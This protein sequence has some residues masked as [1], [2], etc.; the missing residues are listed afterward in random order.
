[1]FTEPVRFERLSFLMAVVIYGFCAP[2]KSSFL[3]SSLADEPAGLFRWPADNNNVLVL[4]FILSEVELHVSPPVLSFI[5]N[6]AIE[7]NRAIS[8]VMK[9]S[10]HAILY[11]NR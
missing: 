7:A 4:S 6:E 8:R 11:R 9:Q 2:L 1:M 5:L 3:Y 10:K